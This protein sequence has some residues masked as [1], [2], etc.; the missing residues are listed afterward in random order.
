MLG[1]KPAFFGELGED[2]F[3]DLG[4]QAAQNELLFHVASKINLSG[5]CFLDVGANIGVTAQMIRM[6]HPDAKIVCMKPSPKS[7]FLSSNKFV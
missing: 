2:Y 6:I 1:R 7:L 3:K 5:E 4:V